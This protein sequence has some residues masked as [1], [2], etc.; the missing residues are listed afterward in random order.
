MPS[1]PSDCGEEAFEMAKGKKSARGRDDLQA[2]A[3]D[4]GKRLRRFERRLARVRDNEAKWERQLGRA[5]ARGA[6]LEDRMTALQSTDQAGT[7]ESEQDVSVGQQAF[8]MRERRKVVIAG[9]T[10]IVLKNGRA[11]VAGTCPTCGARVVTTAR[12]VV[13]PVA[14]G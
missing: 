10:A 8:C 12:S 1:G 11:A 5:R 13:A 14:H 3:K 7:V 9:A 2:G 6:E 4:V